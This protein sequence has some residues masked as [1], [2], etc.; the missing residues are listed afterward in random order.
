MGA[1]Q[2]EGM[3]GGAGEGWLS[4]V[5]SGSRGEAG[6]GGEWERD[7]QD[8]GRDSVACCGRK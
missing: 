8:E 7:V 5:C 6:S 2:A 3:E 1:A 4:G